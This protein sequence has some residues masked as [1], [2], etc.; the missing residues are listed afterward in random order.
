MSDY[1]TSIIILTKEN[2]K[3]L[4]KY[5]NNK[6]ELDFN[7]IFSLSKELD[8]MGMIRS[9][10]KE[11]KNEW[12]EFVSNISLTKENVNEYIEKFRKE[13]R[14]NPKKYPQSSKTIEDKPFE[15]TFGL[16]V[17]D[18]QYQMYRI[19]SKAKYGFYDWYEWQIEN[20]GT[21]RNACNTALL[22]SKIEFETAWNFPIP[23]FE[24]IEKQNPK[25]KFQV[26]LY[27][28]HGDLVEIIG[29]GE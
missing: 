21:N 19:A 13:V 14:K 26:E 5:I 18:F 16:V 25:I 17:P 24:E 7:K 20:W 28:E 12:E 8:K 11:I 15:S 22:E 2:E 1:V 27:D 4:K 29:Y 10:I 23:I 6:G 3:I 9:D